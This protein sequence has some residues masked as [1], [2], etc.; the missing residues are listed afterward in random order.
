MSNRLKR[1]A[2][3]T[4]G[5][6]LL[7]GALGF[8]GEASAAAASS[9]SSGKKL[10][11]TTAKAYPGAR[12]RG[13]RKRR[14][15][16]PL[17]LPEV[18]A[19]GI[20]R[21]HVK[22]AYVEDAATGRVLFQKNPERVYPIASLTKLITV[23]VLL[24]TDPAWDRIVEIVPEDVKNSSRSRIRPR[25]EITVRD[26]IHASLMSSDNVATKA[27]ARTCG[28]SREE[29][30]HRMNLKADSLGLTGTRFVEPGAAGA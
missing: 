11:S 26:L 12:R 18:T 2:V 22:A 20:P 24:D 14:R 3:W 27:L 9:S 1:I 29:F 30:V 6:L 17:R 8:T 16:A 25:E 13:T 21:L 5:A 4:L 15:A 7:V 10:K 19:S 23:M 28:L